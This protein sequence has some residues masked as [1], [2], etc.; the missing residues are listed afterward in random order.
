MFG[1]TGE[2]LEHVAAPHHLV[3]KPN[4]S[5]CPPPPP[6]VADVSEALPVAIQGRPGGKCD[7]RHAGL[8]AGKERVMP[9]ANRPPRTDRE[10]TGQQCGGTADD[11]IALR[12]LGDAGRCDVAHQ[13]T[14][15]TW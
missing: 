13:F 5:W 12:L 4:P 9:M 3:S 7:L 10:R 1:P 11:N 6:C 14:A 15:S 8:H 2:W